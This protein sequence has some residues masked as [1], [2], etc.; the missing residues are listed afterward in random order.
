MC[1][2]CICVC[3]RRPAVYGIQYL[4]DGLYNNEVYE[5]ENEL[6][7][8]EEC[9]MELVVLPIRYLRQME[10]NHMDLRPSAFP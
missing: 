4:Y 5:L 1:Y 7:A 10:S 3:R 8:E 9:I 6:Y 2:V